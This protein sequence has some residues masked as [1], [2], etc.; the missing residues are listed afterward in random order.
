MEA[1]G[2][3]GGPRLDLDEDSVPEY[4]RVWRVIDN[5]GVNNLREMM[6]P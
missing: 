1:R 4:D 2:V 3:S 6:E 5:I